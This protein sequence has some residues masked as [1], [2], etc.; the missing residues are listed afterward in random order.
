ML[1]IDVENSENWLK[2]GVICLLAL[3]LSLIFSVW[4]K[5]KI[6]LPGKDYM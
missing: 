5:N 4:R 3:I 1:F 6:P 2:I